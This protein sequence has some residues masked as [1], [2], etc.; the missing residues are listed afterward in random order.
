MQQ[1]LTYKTEQ[2][3]KMD[4]FHEI[5]LYSIERNHTLHSGVPLSCTAPF[6]QWNA[7][8]KTPIKYERMVSDV[9]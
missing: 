8:V 6:L 5:Y 2:T 3:C 4:N 9:D 1:L 7:Q